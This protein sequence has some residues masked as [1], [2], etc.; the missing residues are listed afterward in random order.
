LR[1][2]LVEM[3]SNSRRLAKRL[4]SATPDCLNAII[5]QSNFQSESCRGPREDGPRTIAAAGTVTVS[6]EVAPCAPG[7]ILA[8]ESAQVGS[9]PVPVTA[10]VRATALLKL[11]PAGGATVIVEVPDAPACSVSDAVAAVTLKS[12][13]GGGVDALLVKVHDSTF[14]LEVLPP[15]PPVKPM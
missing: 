14:W 3:S 7:V 10:Q 4:A 8:G 15:V 11:P 1:W 5:F 12:W 6:V 9:V 2:L 13:L